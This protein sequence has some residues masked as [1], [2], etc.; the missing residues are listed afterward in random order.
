M[1]AAFKVITNRILNILD[2]II[3]R[4]EENFKRS[5]KELCPDHANAIYK[6]GLCMKNSP[7]LKE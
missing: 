3:S 4:T 7:T 1:E 5:I 2:K 6:E